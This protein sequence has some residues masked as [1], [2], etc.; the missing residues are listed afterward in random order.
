MYNTIRYF[1]GSTVYTAHGR[2]MI[3][4]I[5]GSVTGLS[6]TLVILSITLSA[7]SLQIGWDLGPQS[8]Y[9]IIQSVLGYLSCI[10]L[11]G[12]AIVNFVL[13]FLWKSP[14]NDTN[15]VL[16]RCNWDI[17]VIWSGTGLRCESTHATP[18]SLWVL[19]STIR[20]T[21]TLASLVCFKNI[22]CFSDHKNTDVR[23]FY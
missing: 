20:L 21:L 4:L 12:P 3:L 5:L 9:T 19:G 8:V 23:M 1:L 18:W 2:Q 17:D 15:S 10:L 11:T 14:S 16:G 7:L 6:A 22:R 13:V